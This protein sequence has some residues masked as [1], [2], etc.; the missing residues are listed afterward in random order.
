MDSRFGKGY[1]SRVADVVCL[2]VRLFRAMVTSKHRDEERVA[3]LYLVQGWCQLSQHEGVR[4]KM[5]RGW[6]SR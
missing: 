2:L 1:V 5:G 6:P 3:G 4:D